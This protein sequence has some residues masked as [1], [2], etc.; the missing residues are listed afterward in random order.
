MVEAVRRAEAEAVLRA[1]AKA[2]AEVVEAVRRAEAAREIIIKIETS[3]DDPIR[4]VSPDSY[5]TTRNHVPA[6]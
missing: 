3:S 1:E 2:E 4:G 6:R 5:N